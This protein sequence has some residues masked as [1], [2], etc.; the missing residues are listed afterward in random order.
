MVRGGG[1]V[2]VKLIVQ[3][4]EGGRGAVRVLEVLG[5]EGKETFYTLAG[6]QCHCCRKALGE[7]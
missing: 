2:Q 6:F 5:K 3:K 4:G 7:G 1:E